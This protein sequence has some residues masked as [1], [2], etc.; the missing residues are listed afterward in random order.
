MMFE[1]EVEGLFQVLEFEKGP[2]S[3]LLDSRFS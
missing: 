2:G 3:V 1:S